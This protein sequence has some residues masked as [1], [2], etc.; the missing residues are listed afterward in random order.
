MLQ[1]N[2]WNV[3]IDA[4]PLSQ[5]IGGLGPWAPKIDAPW[6]YRRQ[7]IPVQCSVLTACASGVKHDSI[8]TV[9]HFCKVV[10]CLSIR[11]P[12]IDRT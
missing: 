7:C 9:V 8:V 4:W 12:L 3:P 5:N 6:L 10:Q 11:R 2:Y 1:L